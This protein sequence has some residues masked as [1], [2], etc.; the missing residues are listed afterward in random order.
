MVTAEFAVS[1]LALALVVSVLGSGLLIAVRQYQAQ[2]LAWQAGRELARG[3]HE[4]VIRSQVR[5]RMP[6]AQLLFSVRPEQTHVQIRYR[7]NLVGVQALTLS[8]S[9]VAPTERSVG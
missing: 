9:A 5:Q 2:S 3:T 4:E 7:Y 6:E 1:L 8:A